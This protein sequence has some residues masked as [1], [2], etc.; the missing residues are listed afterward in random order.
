MSKYCVDYVII[1]TGS[2]GAVL[3]N[4][5]SNDRLHSVISLEAGQ[6][7]D[8]EPIVVGPN[9]FITVPY[10]M[11]Y[12]WP[13]NTLPDPDAAGRIFNW[14]NG[15]VLGGGSSI[16][17]Q[18]YSR[19]TPQRFN[20]WAAIVG[21][22]WTADKVYAA[23][24]EMES[25]VGFADAC[26]T[27][28]FNGLM[29]I[30]AGIPDSNSTQHFI[31]A[32]NSVN[33]P[34]NVPI[35]DYNCPETPMGHFRPWQLWQFPDG[36]RASSS[37]TFLN[38]NIVDANGRGVNGRKLQVLTQTTATH[39]KW[40]KCGN[41]VKGVFAVK[42]GVPIFIKAN[43]KVI[44]SSGFKSAGFLQVNGI[45]P[46]DVLEAAGV[47]VRVENPNVGLLVNSYFIPTFSVPPPNVTF[48]TNPANYYSAG[49]FLP[50]PRPGSPLDQRNVELSTLLLRP[51][52][53]VV[54]HFLVVESPLRVKSTGFIRIQN[55][56]PLK[57]EEVDIGYLHNPDD[58]EATAATFDLIVTPMI[59]Y[60]QTNF[61]YIQLSPPIATLD[62]P[63]ALRD[64]I[65]NNINNG[66]HYQC[67]TKMGPREQGG[68]VDQWGNVYGTENLL[69]VDNS[70]APLI[71][72][73][74]P[75]SIAEMMAFRIGRHLLEI[76]Q[77][78]TSSCSDD[79][80]DECSTRVYSYCC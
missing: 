22:D 68:V 79:C 19:G 14:T 69:V 3:A 13:G 32:I 43:K 51:A 5:L 31:D 55:A 21:P 16:N 42:N 53:G 37:R 27:H 25:F 9:P 71:I 47:K 7:A 76:D 36:T 24:K 60:L 46:R 44:V 6:N 17:G 10:D 78:S 23:Y 61:G 15:R 39:L 74:N 72:D 50:D 33:P 28:G 11:E 12:Y 2:A 63:V 64:Y 58:L 34:G 35:I 56:D 70:I 41:R 77:D 30:R 54:L 65:R 49:A 29:A 8:N 73:G 66:H 80:S 67:T 52:P 48:N 40:S 38:S 59:K 26:N 20:E 62:D 4:V 57:I 45:G 1:G 18:I 75:N